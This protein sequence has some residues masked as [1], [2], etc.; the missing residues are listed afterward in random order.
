MKREGYR[1]TAKGKSSFQ[2]SRFAPL[3]A[4]LLS[5]LLLV[6]GGYTL[7]RLLPRV[8]KELNALEPDLSCIGLEPTPEP[9]PSPTAEPSPTPILG[10]QQGLF[11]QDLAKLQQ[12]I[13]VG[14]YQ[15]AADFSYR[16]GKLYFAAGNYHTDG[17]ASFVRIL[18]VDL[19]NGS[20]QYF[21]VEQSFRTIRSPRV[22]EDWIVY[23]DAQGQ[24]GGYLRCLDRHSGENKILKTVY[25]GIPELCLGENTVYWLERTGSRR[26]KLFGCDLSS[27]ESVTLA[28]VESH[29]AVVSKPYLQG[30]KLYYVAD[31]G[32]LLCY[33]LTS[34][35]QTVVDTQGLPVHDP[36]SNG[37]E[38]AFMSGYHG[39]DSQLW[40]ID[41]SGTLRKIADAPVDFDIGED[42]VAYSDYDKCYVYFFSDGS[43]FSITRSAEQSQL[44]GAGGKYVYWLDVTWRD[45]DIIEYMQVTGFEE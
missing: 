36:K 43:T 1:S 35:E 12:E 29:A 42:F 2:G 21:S 19:A 3:I 37:R 13:V 17:D 10:Y 9:T 7:I 24:G 15:Y 41:S 34:G 44:I 8:Q 26:F 33:Q 32:E 18:S 31:R 38:L 16:D 6:G 20:K 39:Y 40:Y 25:T 27:G 30:D 28:M 5:L 22:N 11:G 4:I 23:L 45:K 14:E